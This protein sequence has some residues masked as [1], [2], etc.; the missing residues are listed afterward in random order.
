MPQCPSALWP[1]TKTLD[2]PVYTRTMI[3][4]KNR[5]RVNATPG[6][7]LGMAAFS[8]TYTPGMPAYLR[9]LQGCSRICVYSRD[10]HVYGRT[11]QGCPRIWAYTPRTPQACTHAAYVR[12]RCS[13]EQ[14]TRRTSPQHQ[15]HAPWASPLIVPRG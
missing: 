8:H 4:C 6:H 13:A 7:P 11:L 9:I 2:I 14:C 12:L 1:S 5:M 15:A 3:T 10:A